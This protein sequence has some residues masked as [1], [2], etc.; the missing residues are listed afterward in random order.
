M[1]L[2]HST[3]VKVMKV[4]YLFII[5]AGMTTACSQSGQEKSTVQKPNAEVAALKTI[6]LHVKGMS[7]EGC[8]NTIEGAL[9]ELDG[10]SSV[11]ALYKEGIATVSYDTLKVTTD[12]ISETIN[13]LGYEVIN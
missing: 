7:C 6:Q 13:N 9:T 8:E 12:K 5:L 3:I 4:V 1:S 10:I 11:E 2:I